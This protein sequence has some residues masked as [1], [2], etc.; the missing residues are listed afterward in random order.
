MNNSSNLNTDAILARIYKVIFCLNFGIKTGL[1]E[2]NIVI[3]F[4]NGRHF[5]YVGKLII[6]LGF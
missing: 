4:I 1:H 2:N 5:S 3:K 6:G